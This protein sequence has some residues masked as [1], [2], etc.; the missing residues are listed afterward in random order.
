MFKTLPPD[1]FHPSTPLTLLRPHVIDNVTLH[2][3]C[4]LFLKIFDP[5]K[6]SYGVED[7]E[8]AVAQLAQTTMRSELGKLTLDTVFKERSILNSHIVGE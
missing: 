6:A 1:A 4:V 8:T 3:D 5:Y 2:L 7:P